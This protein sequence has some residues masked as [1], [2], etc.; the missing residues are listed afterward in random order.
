[1]QKFILE[2]MPSDDWKNEVFITNASFEE[3][4]LA[5][6]T[7]LKN[8]LGAIV[9]YNKEI[10]NKECEI[11]RDKLLKHCRKICSITECIDSSYS[12]LK[13]QNIALKKVIDLCMQVCSGDDICITIDSSTF[14]RNQLIRLINYIELKLNHNRIRIIYTSPLIHGEWLTRGFSKITNIIGFSGIHNPL[15]PTLLIV[16]SGFEKERLNKIICEHEPTRVLLGI[17]DPPT[18]EEFHDRNI[19]EQKHMLENEKVEEFTFPANDIQACKY[20]L[21]NEIKKYKKDYNIII[22]PLSTKLS[23]V[24]AYLV[25]K[26]NPEIQITYCYPSEY[27]VCKYSEGIGD[28]FLEEI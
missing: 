21:D 25:A 13:E 1:M 10:C 7:Y 19:R 20:V 8:C 28:I 2:Q 11:N 5:P 23:T 14:T 3:R 18:K 17:G 27:N 9:M 22:S 4:C 26:E 16:L 15:L 12:N 6:L 24:A